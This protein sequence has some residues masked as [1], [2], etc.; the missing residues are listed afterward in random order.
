MEPTLPALEH[1][2][3]T[4][5]SLH[6]AAKV[7]S[8]FRKAFSPPLPN[9]LHLSLY[10]RDFG[11]TTGKLP[12]GEIELHLA[13]GRVCTMVGERGHDISLG[14]ASP[15]VLRAAM[16]AVLRDH[17]VHGDVPPIDD[18]APFEIDAGQA[19]DYLTALW[20]I[21]GALRE[22]RADWLGSVT[23]LVVWPHVFDASQLWFRGGNLD[24]TAQPHLAFG[25]SL[26][27]PG[28]PRPYVYAYASPMPAG[29]AGSALPE[30]TRWHDQ[31][32]TGVVIDYDTLRRRGPVTSQLAN[33][34]RQ[35]FT[36]LAAR[37]GE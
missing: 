22:L 8:A 34:L 25:F 21:T 12:F 3:T 29:L 26:E 36:L 5:R 20:Q 9:A 30:G 33:T 16:L 14:G 32:W 37:L 10:I 27:S 7:V 23:P 19:A 31:G 13:D 24:A 1:W 2:E 35:V 4:K 17:G 28:R 6:R 18:Q 15:A 11:L